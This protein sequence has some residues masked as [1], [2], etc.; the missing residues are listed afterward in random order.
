MELA[1][2]V[3]L[4]L[5]SV[6]ELLL[7]LLLDELVL[8]LLLLELLLL[9]LL[10]LELD[11]EETLSESESELSISPVIALISRMVSESLFQSESSSTVDKSIAV[12]AYPTTTANVKPWRSMFSPYVTTAAMGMIM[13]HEQDRVIDEARRYRA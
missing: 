3:L 12:T 6:L 9:L 7:E 4:A 11:E 13:N 5:L 1:V 10:L 8:L 2:V